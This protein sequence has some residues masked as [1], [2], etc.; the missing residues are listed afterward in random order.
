MNS[1]L[2]KILVG[3]G[4]V[5]SL[6]TGYLGNKIN[7]QK[8]LVESKS[9]ELQDGRVHSF[10][11]K[12][13]SVGSEVEPIFKA[14]YNEKMV[15]DKNKEEPWFNISRMDKNRDGI[16]HIS[17]GKL[18]DRKDLALHKYG[19]NAIILSDGVTEKILDSNEERIDVSKD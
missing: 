7:V 19:R 6:L 18:F 5:G 10:A 11:A 1:K 9:V 4:I 8:N 3:A 15:D 16:V 12:P 14:F 17:N 13:D 2:R